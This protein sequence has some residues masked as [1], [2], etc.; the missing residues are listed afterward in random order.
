MFVE[1]LSGVLVCKE[2]AC[3]KAICKKYVDGVEEKIFRLFKV[4]GAY[5]LYVYPVLAPIREGAKVRYIRARALLIALSSESR[6][7]KPRH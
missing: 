6:S 4:F 7:P 2:A 1:E 3:E 5:T